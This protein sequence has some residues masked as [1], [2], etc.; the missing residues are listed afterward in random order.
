MTGSRLSWAA[1]RAALR[2]FAAALAALAIQALVVQEIRRNGVIDMVIPWDDCAY[3]YNALH[4]AYRIRAVG[5][6]DALA[7]LHFAHS[8]LTNIHA[9]TAMLLSADRLWSAHVVPVVYLFLVVFAVFRAVPAAGW[10]IPI[11]FVVMMISVPMFFFFTSTIKVDYLAG[12]LLF[13]LL[14]DVF[15]VDRSKV[16][17]AR[18]LFQASLAVLFVLCKPT[19][20]FFPFLIALIFLLDAACRVVEHGKAGIGL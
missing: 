1:D 14:A 3:L 17:L 6:W 18:R 13:V 11:G 9:T 7:D 8:P 10:I 19:A 2:F 5:F 4:N 15:L 12:A 16:G 20:F